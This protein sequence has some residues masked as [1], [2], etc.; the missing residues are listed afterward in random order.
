MAVVGVLRR[1]GLQRHRAAIPAVRI[2]EAVTVG[3]L[4]RRES[5]IERVLGP[6]YAATTGRG[7]GGRH[8]DGDPSD[9]VEHPWAVAVGVHSRHASSLRPLVL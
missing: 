6:R 5:Q 2:E 4:R 9:L 8:G 1:I 3:V 7:R